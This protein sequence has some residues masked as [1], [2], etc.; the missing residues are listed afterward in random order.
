MPS[1]PISQR[2]ARTAITNVRVFGSGGLGEPTTVVIE[3]GI[4]SDDSS[5]EDALVIDAAGGTLLPGLIDTHVHARNRGQLEAAADAGVTTLIDL[6][7]ADLELLRSLQNLP[8]LP[9]LRSSGRSASGPGSVF[10]EKMGMPV[11]SGVDGPSDAERFIRERKAEG[12]EFIKIL[13]E[14]PKFPG[15]KPLSTE[16]VAAIVRAAHD[17]EFLTIAHVV[18]A[19]TLRS[20]LNAGVDVITHAALGGELDAET[21]ALIAKNGTTI[22]PT[23]GMMQ[24]IV[25]TIGGK[26]M[27]K[28]VGLFVPAARMKYRFAETTVRSFQQAGST[29]LVGSDANDDHAAPYQVQ[30]GEG[31]HDE[32]ARLVDAGLT[33]VEAIDGATSKAVQVFGLSD[34]GRIAPGLRADLLLLDGDPT[35]DISATRNIKGV[36]IAGEKV[37]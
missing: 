20:A 21:Q 17:A 24:G 7:S 30:F 31:V 1:D 13:I 26:L 3:G 2:F 14:D 12:S 19:F 6:G 27:M 25:E 11:S 22:I 4:I 29:V 8:G 5:A 18:S 37:R 16:T 33:P 35:R 10:I 9:S 23:L 15:T 28:I 36:W 32:L 34:R